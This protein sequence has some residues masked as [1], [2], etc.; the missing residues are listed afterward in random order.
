MAQN[1]QKDLDTGSGIMGHVVGLRYHRPA[2]DC[3]QLQVQKDEVECRDVDA[4]WPCLVE[5]RRRWMV[6]EGLHPVT[7]VVVTV[8]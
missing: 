5:G 4:E 3:P 7:R 8:D 6:E 1:R 2:V